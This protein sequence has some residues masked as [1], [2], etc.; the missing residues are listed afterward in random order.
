MNR[1][2]TIYLVALVA[3]VGL[4]TACIEDDVSTNVAHQPQFSTDTLDM[5]LVFTQ[6]GTPTHSFTVYNR[7]V[8]L[9]YFVAKCRVGRFS[10]K[11]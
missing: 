4:F 6:A 9:K 11:C 10:P 5:G 3:V 2:K 8:N 7:Y 1:L